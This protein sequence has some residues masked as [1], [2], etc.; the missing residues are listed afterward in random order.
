MSLPEDGLEISVVE[1]SRLLNDEA[2]NAVEVRLVDCRETDEFAL[3]RIPGAELMPLSRFAEEG[4]TQLLSDL[5]RPVI[6]YCH[7]GMRSLQATMFLRQLGHEKVWSMAGGIEAWS[8]EVD[9]TVPR[10]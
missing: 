6:V 3:C 4:R 5:S 1:V 7:H 2:G 8:I 10:Y 9:S